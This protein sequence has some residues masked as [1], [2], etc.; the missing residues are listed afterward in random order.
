MMDP[1]G[2]MTKSE[3][4]ELTLLRIKGGGDNKIES[5]MQGALL[6]KP[7]ASEQGSC[8]HEK[9][10]HWKRSNYSGSLHWPRW[11]HEQLCCPRVAKHLCGFPHRIEM[12]VGW[13]NIRGTGI[14]MDEARNLVSKI[15]TMMP[16]AYLNKFNWDLADPDRGTVDILMMTFLWFND[17]STLHDRKRVQLDIQQALAW[18]PIEIKEVFVRATLEQ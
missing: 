13:R 5:S 7:G 1:F 3:T 9:Q 2:K 14:T 12:L 18:T 11:E 15:K 10:T 6:F 16:D 4:M 8:L 17:G